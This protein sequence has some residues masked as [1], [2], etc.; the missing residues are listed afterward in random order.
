M[1]AAGEHETATHRYH[2]KS[3]LHHCCL[4]D[5]SLMFLHV[6]L[7]IGKALMDMATRA[8]MLCSACAHQHH[9]GA[10]AGSCDAAGA[11]TG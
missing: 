3:M 1:S 9:A 7:A 8:L 2:G 11:C 4:A 5:I 6:R 10:L